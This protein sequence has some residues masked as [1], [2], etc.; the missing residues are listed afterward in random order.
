MYFGNYV[1]GTKGMS[2]LKYITNDFEL[3]G[4]VESNDEK[5]LIDLLE[6][7]TKDTTFMESNYHKAIA[8][9]SDKFYWSKIVNPLLKKLEE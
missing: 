8:Q 7:V 1:I 3:G 4:V 5:A 9:I 2:S 6:K